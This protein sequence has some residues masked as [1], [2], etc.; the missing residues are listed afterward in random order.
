MQPI[1]TES[2]VTALLRSAKALAVL[3]AWNELG[4]FRALAEGPRPLGAL[5]ADRR[6]LEISLPVLQHLGLVHRDGERLLLSA[7]GRRLLEE[8]ALP[9]ARNF[10]FLRDQARMG[11]VLEKGG[12][13]ASDEGGDKATEGGVRRDDPQSSA[14]FLDMLYGRSVESAAQ[15]L[16]SL[17]PL[18]STT[19]RVLDLGG[20]HGRYARTFADAG[21]A[22]TLFD[23]PHVVDYARRRHGEALDYRAGDFRDPEVVFGGPYDLVF[24][25]NIVHGES[26][27]TNRGL[28]RRLADALAPGGY[29]VLKDMFLDEHGQDPENAVFFGLTMLFYTRE[30]CSH[31]TSRARAWLREAGLGEPELVVREGFQLLRS[32]RSPEAS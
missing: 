26:D 21:H 5:A 30:G 10:E 13:V 19:A 11:E 15:C 28:V 16:D 32:R 7:A 3:T 17:A 4:L 31:P 1:R 8:G 22:A 14:R 2:D 12:P 29:L 24:L 27:A 25:S 9:T 23:L 18:L 20:G 6:A